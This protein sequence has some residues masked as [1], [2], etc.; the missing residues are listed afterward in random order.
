VDDAGSK[1]KPKEIELVDSAQLQQSA[2]KLNQDTSS[3]RP[4]NEEVKPFIVFF[5]IGLRLAI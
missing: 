3:G 1:S 2:L 4:F 5:F